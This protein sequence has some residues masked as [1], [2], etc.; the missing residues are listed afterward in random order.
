[1]SAPAAPADDAIA[2]MLA[3]MVAWDALY[4]RT[5][6]ELGLRASSAL[7]VP[8]SSG[9]ARASDGQR[10]RRGACRTR[11]LMCAR[12]SLTPS[13]W[14]C[15]SLR[16]RIGGSGHLPDGYILS[17]HPLTL[18]IDARGQFVDAGEGAVASA[19]TS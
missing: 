19:S 2:L 3:M 17:I 13:T 6:L 16:R 9:L 15:S 18:R 5:P 4:R 1:M 10:R 12:S 11:A 14:A 7:S 8:A